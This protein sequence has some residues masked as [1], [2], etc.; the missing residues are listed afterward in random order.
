MRVLVMVWLFNAAAGNFSI[1]LYTDCVQ[2]VGPNASEHQAIL[3]VC[4]QVKQQV[5]L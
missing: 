5:R 1:Q 3:L 2:Y 4:L